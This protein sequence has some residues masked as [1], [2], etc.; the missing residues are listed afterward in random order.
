MRALIARINRKLQPELEALKATRGGRARVD[1]GD[2]YVIDFGRNFLVAANVDPEVY[3]RELGVL[4][5]YEAVEKG[6]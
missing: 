6:E 5:D 3:E 4:R 2:L 1:L